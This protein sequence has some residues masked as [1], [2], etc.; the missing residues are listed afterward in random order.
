MALFS[1][2]SDD[3][4]VRTDDTSEGTVSRESRID[5]PDPETS[6]GSDGSGA[7]IPKNTVGSVGEVFEIAR[8]VLGLP[9]PSEAEDLPAYVRSAQAR[10]AEKAH[11]R[12]LVACWSKH[13]GYITIH[14]PATGERH[15]LATKDAP[16]WAKW[17]AHR[18]KALYKSSDRQAYDLSATQL[19]EIWEA[20]HP[21]D[22]GLI[23]E[24]H[25]LPE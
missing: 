3:R 1:D 2:G 16:P 18:R 25:P 13:F 7:H 9:A 14:D 19:K 20:E 6:D 11:K 10:R 12:G 23:V 15:D 8:E 4:T 24:D 22:P 21:P 17:E 5:K